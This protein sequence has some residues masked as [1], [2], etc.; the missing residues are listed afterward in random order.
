ML[1]AGDAFLTGFAFHFA[2]GT[3]RNPDKESRVTR[4][5]RAGNRRRRCYLITAHLVLVKPFA[6]GYVLI[7]KATLTQITRE[8][9]YVLHGRRFYPC[10]PRHSRRGRVFFRDGRGVEASA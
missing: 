6:I 5:A 1:G 3:W 7:I 2:T 8:E 9:V 4:H 10:R